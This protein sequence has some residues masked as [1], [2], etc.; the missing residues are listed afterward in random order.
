MQVGVGY[1][2]ARM[3]LVTTAAGR[4]D[5]ADAEIDD[6]T[7]SGGGLL[8]ITRD[9]ERAG[10]SPE[11]AGAMGC[12]LHGTRGGAQ[13]CGV[14]P[15]FKSREREVREETMLRIRLWGHS[16]SRSTESQLER[17]QTMP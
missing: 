17:P 1:E 3:G 11:A 7:V 10:I 9:L 2:A 16:R 15:G 8:L 4:R 14:V 5:P 13:R 12:G 6:L